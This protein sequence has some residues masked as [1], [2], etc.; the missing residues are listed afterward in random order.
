[1]CPDYVKMVYELYEGMEAYRNGVFSDW[2][3]ETHEIETT[4]PP[5]FNAWVRSRIEWEKRKIDN[6]FDLMGADAIRYGKEVV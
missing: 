2:Y 6:T 5:T 3:G 1:M 4:T